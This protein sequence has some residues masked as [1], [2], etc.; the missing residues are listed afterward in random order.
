MV[1]EAEPADAAG[2]PESGKS[3]TGSDDAGV[4]PASV[5]EPEEAE[6][7]PA[8][9]PEPEDSEV[10]PESDEELVE[11]VLMPESVMELDEES[12]PLIQSVTP[13]TASEIAVTTSL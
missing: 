8:S 5:T 1:S 7:V 4:E 12:E 9:D 10:F 11:V 13:V 2:S 6:V 3:L